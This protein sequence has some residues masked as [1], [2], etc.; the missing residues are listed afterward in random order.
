MERQGQQTNFQAHQRQARKNSR[1]LTLA[2]LLGM[3]L[4]ALS[5]FFITW[6]FLHDTGIGIWLSILMAPDAIDG[7]GTKGINN[8]NLGAIKISAVIALIS[9]AVILWGFFTKKSELQ[10]ENADDIAKNL[11]AKAL[12]EQR[13][14]Q[15]QQYVNV[16]EEMAI[17]S[18]LQPPSILYLPHD[19]SINGFVTGGYDESVAIAV[20]QGA[21][22][23]LNREELQ[24][25]VAHEFGH[26]FN[27]DVFLNNRLTAVLHG[28]F[29]L[30]DL[31]TDH[32][33]DDGD[34]ENYHYDRDDDDST[35]FSVKRSFWGNSVRAGFRPRFGFWGLAII[36]ISSGTIFF[37]KLLQAAFSR[38]REWLADA[39]AVQYTRNKDALVGVFAKAMALQQMQVTTPHVADESAHF[40]FINYHTKW[41]STHPPMEARMARYGQKLFQDDLQALVYK[42]KQ[43]K[44]DQEQATLRA[45]QNAIPPKGMMTAG[46]AL[47]SLADNDSGEAHGVTDTH[48]AQQRFISE[49]FIPLLALREYQT[50]LT[51]NPVVSPD[52]AANAVLAQFVAL[53][54]ISLEKV[55][56]AFKWSQTQ[57]KAIQ[58]HIE[59]LNE[60]H[61]GTH[62]QT[63]LHQLPML[64]QFDGKQRLVKQV[65]AIIQA[66]KS[67]DLCEMSYLLCLRSAL[68]KQPTESQRQ[69]DFKQYTNDIALLLAVAAHISHEDEKACTT[70]YELMKNQ[71]MPM[72]DTVYHTPTLDDK[73]VK[74]LYQTI[75]RI[76]SVKAVYRKNL[77]SAIEKNMLLD[78]KLSTEQNHLLFALKQCW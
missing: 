10:D 58:K 2:F 29:V 1:R 77:L 20:S 25:L 40:L 19:H 9:V 26:I 69:D 18:G 70:N 13:S 75:Q 45:Q 47:L 57:T 76:A 55:A 51:Q 52:D 63:F 42:M 16:V 15:Q 66:D 67:F 5:Y 43:K 53:G 61:P 31:L 4:S 71:A 50:G 28:F 11:S 35:H 36:A 65:S 8:V 41:L 78:G 30:K 14:L 48:T 73:T 46:G 17:A 44:H 21:L 22:D 37:G 68:Q 74:Q 6:L 39:H 23:Y 27:R 38:Q 56:K 60:Q 3:T 33:D 72:L 64:R 34:D 7:S 59:L 62:I 12:P 32:N 24:A 54:N 49:K